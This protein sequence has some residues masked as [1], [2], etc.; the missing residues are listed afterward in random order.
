MSLRHF[1]IGFLIGLLLW[2]VPLTFAAY[3]PLPVANEDTP[4]ADGDP[5]IMLGCR[6][7]DSP[8]NS[9]GTTGDRQSIDCKSGGISA[10][11]VGSDIG[12]TEP[13]MT[14]TKQQFTFS[15]STATTT[16]L[17]PNLSGTGN[18]YYVCSIIVSNTGAAKIAFVDDDTDNC[19]S[20]TS[21]LSGGTTAATGWSLAANDW[22]MI[23]SGVSW[24]MKT[25]G[26]N[27]VLCAVT[28]TAT[29]YSGT[30]TVVAA[31]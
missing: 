8:T 3:S 14:G 30:I 26:T 22:R 19:V 24:V 20:V 16:E 15:I 7:Q 13:C 31:P 12:T 2:P 18:N 23:G 10:Y 9:S 17:T 5:L 4:T 11:I 6:R 1:L 27:R 28:D 21:G 25:N 29:Q